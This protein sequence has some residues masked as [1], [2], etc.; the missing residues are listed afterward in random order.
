MPVREFTESTVQAAEQE[1]V[2]PNGFPPEAARRYRELGL[3]TGQTHWGM[4]EETIRR[5]PDRLAVSDAARRL[6][7][8][9]LGDA[10][11]TASAHLAAAGVRE[12]ERVVVQLPNA[13]VFLDVVLA[14]FRLGAVPVFALPAHGRLEVG[15]FCRI[16]EATHYVGARSA[17][18][19]AAAVVEGL[20][21]E[22]PGVRIVTVDHRAADPWAV[23]K[24]ASA[25]AAPSADA[26]PSA[27]PSGIAV[28]E[29]AAASPLE[30][31]PA[32]DVDP[33]A[34][35]FLQLSGGTTGVPKLIPRTHDDYLYSVRRSVELCDVRPGDAM[36][37]ALPCAHNFTMSSPGILGALQVGAAVV[38]APDPSPATCLRLI[39]EHGIAQAALVPPL[40]LS[41]LNA[42]ERTR[43]DLSSLR[44]LWV[45][46]AKLSESVARR[47]GPELGCVLQ[48]VFGMAEGLVNYTRLDDAVD[49]VVGTQGAPMS[50]HDE[51][52]LVDDHDRPV[53]DGEPG[54]LQ[55]RGPYTIRR[56]YRAP[57][58]DARSFTE[59]GFYRTGDI[60]RLTPG[61][62]LEV[63]GRAKD[64]INRGGEKVAP[65]AVENQ[66]LAHDAVHDVSV[67]GVPDE[68]LGE[69]ICAYVILRP[70]AR[71]QA[72]TLPQLRAFLRGRGL[73]RFAM[74]DLLRVVE[75]F[76]QTGVGKVS[77]KHQRGT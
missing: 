14:L 8:A 53:P 4:A 39:A 63:V 43:H 46:G 40:L 42:P 45:G 5:H 77:K 55:T 60:V 18:A 12:G 74:P 59:D 7:Y 28:P 35:A 71:E 41:W 26:A 37:V 20:R 17:G 67:V 69:R 73:A 25:G 66:I 56:Y 27:A 57:E 52:R 62:Y 68:V 49:T 1:A 32:A 16:A 36:L 70:E 22:H 9:E 38:I 11:R 23:E 76:P 34:L 24:G 2:L 75:E 44:T 30:A 31:P 58:H 54:H 3:W 47:V 65:E 51:V 72:P 15:H 29:G 6:T 50:E 64:Q 21:E 33:A 10:V 13:A 61:R 48:Q 19:D